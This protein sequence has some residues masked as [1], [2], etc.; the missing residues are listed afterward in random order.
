MEIKS[1]NDSFGPDGL[2][3]TLAVY[4]ALP[5]LGL[6]SD[7]PTP[8]TFQHAIE[9]RIATEE[10]SRHFAR[11]KISSAVKTRNGPDTSDINTAPIDL[12][13]LV[14]R[15]EKD[16]WE[17]QY[18]LLEVQD[19]TCTVLLPPPKD[20]FKFRSR[21]AKRFFPAA[22]S[23][24]PNEITSPN[25]VTSTAMILNTYSDHEMEQDFLQKEDDSTT[26][27]A[28][29]YSTDNQKFAGSHGK[30][31]NDLFE[32]GVS[33]LSHKDDAQALRIY[34]AMFA[35]Q[36]KNEGTPNEIEK[37]RLVI[38]GFNDK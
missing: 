35:N 1:V 28:A 4:G 7:P 23:R 18:T 16:R 33:T 30:E 13:V 6:P 17:G 3:P 11:W 26:Y 37:S 31:V 38:R 19:E 5:R 36:V 32:Q 27:H 12:H 14:Y 2:V 8:S 24:H 9:V 22:P 25:N 10:V 15:P 21:V 20:P 29:F 34:G